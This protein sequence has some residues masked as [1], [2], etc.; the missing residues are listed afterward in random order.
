MSSQPADRLNVERWT[1]SAPT[2]PELS[3]TAPRNT[4]EAPS[5]AMPSAAH[6]VPS[7]AH[8]AYL[9]ALARERWL[10]IGVRLAL[11]FGFFALWEAA[12]RLGWI[13]AFIVSQPSKAYEAAAKLAHSGQ[14]LTHLWFTTW[15]TVAGFV[16]GTALGIALAIG[17]WWSEFWSRVLEPY[18]V[19]VNSIPKVAIG[20]IFIVWLG[21]NPRAIVAMA[22]AISFI[23]TLLMVFT[24][25][26]QVDPNRIKLVK[27][28][29]ANK[30][31]ILT[32]VILP[33]SV[34]TM[35]GALKVN[36]GLSFVGTITGEFLVSSAG[37]G[38]LIVYGGQVFNMSLV[39]SSL[40]ILVALS[41]ILYYLVSALEHWITRGWK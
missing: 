35:I 33:A 6:P 28:F 10:I 9:R 8:M 25:F 19:V 38:Y 36:V 18:I 37:L 21:T 22:V 3:N 30:P 31:Q 32:K 26:R 2:A 34:P 7:A 5:S 16:L 39:M 13:N 15:E 23:V 12:A 17:L 40:L 1:V 27:S 14:L 11:L 29:G 20:P 4:A 24:G 41:T